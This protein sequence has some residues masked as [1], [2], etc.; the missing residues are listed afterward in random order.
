MR[1][2]LKHRI[3]ASAALAGAALAACG[4]GEGGSPTCGI[5]AVAAPT[6]LLSEFSVP[7]RTLG[8]APRQVPERLTARVAAGP[9]FPAVVGR[10][11]SLLVVGVE[12]TLPREGRPGF[13]VLVVDS[14]GT[15]RGVM[16][17]QGLPVEGA[18]VIGSVSVADTT[19]PL[20]GIQVDVARFQEPGCPLFG[21]SAAR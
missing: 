15:S 10:T 6:Q 17:Y 14:D 1:T 11:D 19:V 9:T 16:L 20:V 2:P 12:D 5:A 13:G 18:P 8:G 7:N 4:G 3:A 21:D